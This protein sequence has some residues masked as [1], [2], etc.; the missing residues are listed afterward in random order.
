MSRMTSHRTPSQRL[1]EHLTGKDIASYLTEKRATGIS[2]EGIA[3]DIHDDTDGQVSVSQSTV[4][5]WLIDFGLLE[6][7][8]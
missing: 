7:V 8:S 3:R 2:H 5:G 6:A 4:R 1:F